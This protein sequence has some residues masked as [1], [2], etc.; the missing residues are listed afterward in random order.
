MPPG[1]GS[2]KKRC[3]MLNCSNAV[4]GLGLECDRCAKVAAAVENFKQREL[5]NLRATIEKENASMIQQ[6][7][8]D[9]PL[10]VP[11]R[12]AKTLGLFSRW[13]EPPVAST[14]GPKDTQVG[15]SKSVGPPPPPGVPKVVRIPDQVKDGAEMAKKR[16]QTPGRRPKSHE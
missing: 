1:S 7:P 6:P 9:L 13:D 2:V 4:H 5:D 14:T 10:K 12:T 3:T 8:S 11:I 16:A 15:R